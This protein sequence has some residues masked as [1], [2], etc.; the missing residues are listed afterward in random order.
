MSELLHW[1]YY[2]VLEDDF[3]KTNRYVEVDNRNAAT[4][5]IEFVHLLLAIGSEVDVVLKE[6]CER[7]DGTRGPTNIDAYRPIVLAKYKHFFDARLFIPKYAMPVDPWG[8]WS[9]E[10]NPDWWHAYNNVKHRRNKCFPEANLENVIYS[11]A[12]LYGAILHL[13]GFVNLNHAPRH[14]VVYEG[15]SFEDE[16]TV[17]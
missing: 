7:L 16:A 5:S 13:Y 15:G 14:L 12:G 9:I 10:K 6:M 11:L 17:K 1:D 8:P 2:R 4:Y 3:E